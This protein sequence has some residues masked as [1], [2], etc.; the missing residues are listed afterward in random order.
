MGYASAVA[1]VLFLV[2]FILGKVV[3]KALSSREE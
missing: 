3:M 1:V 2:T